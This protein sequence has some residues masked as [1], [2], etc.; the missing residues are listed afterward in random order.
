LVQGRVI[1]RENEKEQQFRLTLDPVPREKVESLYPIPTVL[2]SC[3]KE[4]CVTWVAIFILNWSAFVR[5]WGVGGTW[6][7]SGLTQ[8]WGT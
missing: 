7:C 5:G 1:S 2:P 3:S 6:D 4:G 8:S